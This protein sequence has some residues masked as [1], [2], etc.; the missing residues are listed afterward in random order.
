MEGT[1]EGTPW[2][3]PLKKTPWRGKTGGIP[4]VG[5]PWWRPLGLHR[6]YGTSGR[7]VLLETP[8]WGTPGWGPP[9]GHTWWGPRE[10]PWKGPTGDVP[11]GDPLEW[12]PGGDICRV[13]MQG[14]PWK[15]LPGGEPLNE[16][17]RRLEGTPGGAPP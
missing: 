8:W 11:G 1:H 4:V 13:P 9:G 3:D 10:I 2:R 15:G 6:L 12:T 16:P 5:S 17:W 14:N 7:D